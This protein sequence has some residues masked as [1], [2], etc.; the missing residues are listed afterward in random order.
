MH[1]SHFVWLRWLV[2]SQLALALGSTFAQ[3]V[4]MTGSM[5]SKALLV[6]DGGAPKALSGG[7]SYQG[8]K[9]VSVTSDRVVVETAGK[10]QTVL[11]GGAPV[12][13]GG[14]SGGAQIVLVAAEGGHFLAQ[15]TINGMS[16]RFVVDTGATLI[17]MGV[18]E[19]KRLGLNYESGKRIQTS[20]ANGPALGWK[21]SLTSVRI[22]NVEVN[23][24]DAA[25]LPMSMPFVLLGNSFLQRFQMQRDNDTL[26]LKR[27]F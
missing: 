26:T 11:L 7:E 21:L 20:T 23:Q 25:I 9:V 17:S 1:S 16:T 6:I 13:I 27:R 10:R 8:V 12:S 15:G 2:C 3:S 5:G 22:Q 4:A 18:D 24:V 19:A 14:G